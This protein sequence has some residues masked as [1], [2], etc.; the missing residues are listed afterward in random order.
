ME[1]FI[2][3]CCVFRRNER[4][5]RESSGQPS[6]GVMMVVL[7]TASHVSVSL[8][9]HGDYHSQYVSQSTGYSVLL[10]PR[11]DASPC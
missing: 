8:E 9:Y 4:V 7:A 10:Y 1:L 6:S 5:V 3:F 2:T 11:Q